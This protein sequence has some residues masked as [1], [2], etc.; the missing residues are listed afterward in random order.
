MAGYIAGVHSVVYPNAVPGMEY[1]AKP[2]VSSGDYSGF[3]NSYLGDMKH[4]APRI[5]L[6]WDPRGSGREVVRAAYG[7]FYD[8][9]SFQL[10]EVMYQGPPFADAMTL[11]AV[12]LTNPFATFTYNGKTGVDP[13]PIAQTASTPFITAGSYASF[14]ELH[15]KAPMLQQWNLSFEKQFAQNWSV[16]ASYIG[17]HGVHNVIPGDFNPGDLYSWQLHGET[18]ISRGVR[19]RS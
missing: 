6:S 14:N 3:G 17:N 11:Q 5:G 15:V 1:P 19:R 13:F 8:F 7:I 10:N 16:T 4:F 12:N 18:A 2:G 9:A